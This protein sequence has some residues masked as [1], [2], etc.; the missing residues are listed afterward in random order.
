MKHKK[1]IIVI[2]IILLLIIA[3]VVAGVTFFLPV[4]SMTPAATGKIGDTGITAIKNNTSGVYFYDTGDG[5]IIIDTGSDSAALLTSMNELSINPDDIKYVFITHTDYDHMVSLNNFK[6]AQVYL[7]KNEKQ[8]IDGTTKRNS[9]S[10]NRLPADV[11]IDDMAWLENGEIVEINGHTVEC[12][13]APGHTT[14]SMV[15]LLDDKYLFTGDAFKVTD[16]VISVHPFTR[17]EK[18]AEE[19]ISNLKSVFDKSELILTSHYGYYKPDE[20]K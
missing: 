6:N 11:S 8:M 4:S 12:I 10:K 13:D 1:L 18:T 14:G 3:V 16:D 2:S 17:D 15:Y 19:T 9:F 7:S 5:Y 20:I